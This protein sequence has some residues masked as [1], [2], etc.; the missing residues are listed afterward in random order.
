LQ[1]ESLVEYTYELQDEIEELLQ[2]FKRRNISYLKAVNNEDEASSVI[3]KVD[4]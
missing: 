1:G 4:E 2:E 3:A